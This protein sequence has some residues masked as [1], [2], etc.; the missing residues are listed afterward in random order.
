MGSRR[1]VVVALIC[2]VGLLGGCGKTEPSAAVAP[3]SATEPVRVLSYR[4]DEVMEPL[5][6]RFTAETNIPTQLE[7]RSGEGVV[8]YFTSPPAGPIPDLIVVVDSQRLAGIAEAGALRALPSAALEQIPPQWRDTQGRWLGLS[9]RLRAVLQPTDG[10]SVGYREL[11]DL[12]ANGRRVCVRG[13]DH[14]Y[15]RGLLTW[16]AGRDGDEAAQRWAAAVHGAR[17]PVE[18]GDRDQIRAL[19]RGECDYAVVNHYYLARMLHE[20]DDLELRQRLGMLRFGPK[21][22]HEPSG[23]YGNLSGIAVTREGGNQAGAD[24]LALWLAA[25][26]NQSAYAAAVFEFPA[27]WPDGAGTLPPALDALK[28]LRVG[29]PFPADLGQRR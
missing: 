24:R 18:G 5:L 27:A 1:Q 14:V 19:T 4:P 12:V 9:W 6:A 11:T 22:E 10:G 7:V 20:T 17:Q 29:P 21:P 26:A 15:N 8:E 28:H 16:L 2:C 25:P 3:G 13:G 23:L